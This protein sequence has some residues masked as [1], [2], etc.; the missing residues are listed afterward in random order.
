MEREKSWAQIYIESRSNKSIWDPF[1]DFYLVL[2]S[3]LALNANLTISTNTGRTTHSSFG[4]WFCNLVI[5]DD[6]VG[7][8]WVGVSVEFGEMIWIC[9]RSFFMQL[10]LRPLLDVSVCLLHKFKSC[11]CSMCFNKQSSCCWFVNGTK[12]FHCRKI[13]REFCVKT[14]CVPSLRESLNECHKNSTDYRLVD[15]RKKKHNKGDPNQIHKQI[16][17]QLQVDIFATT[18]VRIAALM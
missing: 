15:G 4:F 9:F 7:V 18:E 13:R 12:R 14:I 1:I 3:S 16:W 11:E 2:Q 5:D 8:R 6:V 10:L 17:Y